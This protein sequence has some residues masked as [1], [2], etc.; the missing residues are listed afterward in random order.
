MHKES[1][2]LCKILFP[3]MMC[4]PVKVSNFC[5]TLVNANRHCLLSTD[6]EQVRLYPQ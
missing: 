1:D 2:H 6:I 5:L 3:R 4:K